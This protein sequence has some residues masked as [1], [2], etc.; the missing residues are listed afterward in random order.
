MNE[1]N[2][3]AAR[4]IQRGWDVLTSDEEQVGTVD[5]VGDSSFTVAG[6]AGSGGV[7][8]IEFDDVESA[9]DGR[10]ILALS[11]DELMPAVETT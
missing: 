3:I 4:E 6:L 8:E 7:L 5:D 2:E 10:V 11:R 1:L 9:D